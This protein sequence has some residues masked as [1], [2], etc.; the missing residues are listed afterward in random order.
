MNAPINPLFTLSKGLV[1]CSIS[2][3]DA[4]FI[5]IALL[6]SGLSADQSPRAAGARVTA[7]ASARI[8]SAEAIS[9]TGN[10]IADRNV[11]LG[12]GKPLLMRTVNREARAEGQKMV[13]VEFH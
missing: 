9:M 4:L 10:M 2:L 12:S 8:V 6:A 11:D 3:M 1:F 5:P 7:V 13:V